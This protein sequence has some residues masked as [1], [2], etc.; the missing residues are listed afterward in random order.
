M[1]YLVTKQ[2][3]LF[4]SDLYKIID[5]QTALDFMKDWTLVQYDCETK[6]TNPYIGT[7][8]C[9]Q[10]GNDK[11][12]TRI[13]VDCTTVSILTFKEILEN[14]RLIGHNL[15]FDIQWLYNFGIIP[16]KVYDTMI[17]EQFL[18][19]GYSSKEDDTDSKYLVLFNLKDVAKR[20]LG[21]DID[22]SVRGQIIWRGLDRD[23]INYAQN[24]VVWLERIMQSQLKD[25]RDSL[26]RVVWNQ[27]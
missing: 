25:L 27:A 13:V 7:L 26:S 6:G 12:N 15:K 14:K 4:E 17:V 9:A 20:R 1:I 8:L 11:T 5:A 16:R 21:V 24:D 19:L 2:Q 22:K 23:T 10:F 18:Y 3:E